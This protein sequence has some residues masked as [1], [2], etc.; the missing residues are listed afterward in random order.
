M[1]G[2]G[3]DGGGRS[4]DGGSPAPPTREI[5]EINIILMVLIITIY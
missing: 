1:G 2:Q 5:P 4:R 3:L